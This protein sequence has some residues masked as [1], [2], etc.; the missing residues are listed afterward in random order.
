MAVC[1]LCRIKYNIKSNIATTYYYGIKCKYCGEPIF[2]KIKFP[3]SEE[4]VQ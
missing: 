2:K 4:D 3:E 1:N